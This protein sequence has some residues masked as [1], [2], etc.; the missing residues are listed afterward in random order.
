M[1]DAP[2]ASQR[3]LKRAIGHKEMKESAL[4]WPHFLLL[5][6]TL[7]AGGVGGSCIGGGTGMGGGFG[8][9]GGS[10]TGGGPGGFGTPTC[11]NPVSSGRR[12]KMR[13]LTVPDVWLG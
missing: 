7:K 9:G 3:L 6:P 12:K 1:D 4:R 5:I 10:G 2:S 8:A 11:F 13:A